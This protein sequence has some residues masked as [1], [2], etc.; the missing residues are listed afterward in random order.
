MHRIC[1]NC[2][3]TEKVSQDHAWCT[4]QRKLSSIPSLTRQEFVR[5]HSSSCNGY[6]QG[7]P[8]SLG[9]VNIG[10][11]ERKREGHP[12]SVNPWARL[13]RSFR[14]SDL[15]ALSP[16][17]GMTPILPSTGKLLSFV[18]AYRNTPRQ[19]PISTTSFCNVDQ[20]MPPG[21]D[22]SQRDFVE[23]T[24]ERKE[25]IHDGKGDWINSIV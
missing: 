24:R 11:W 8:F 16:L 18:D 6:A 3:S 9:P 19:R 25:K 7:N 22:P 23:R 1:W 17:E 4:L 12:P 5:P 20:H 14:K 2:S 15:A 10:Y 13:T 21:F